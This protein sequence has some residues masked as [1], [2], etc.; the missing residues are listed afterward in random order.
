VNATTLATFLRKVGVTVLSFV[1][2]SLASLVLG[3]VLSVLAGAVISIAVPSTTSNAV[4]VV[5]VL[6]WFSTLAAGLGVGYCVNRVALGR[7]ASWVWVPGL[8]WFALGIRSSMQNY[9]PRWYEGCTAAQNVMNAFFVGDSSKCGGGASTLNSAAFTMP[10]F[11]SIGYSI[12]AW[13]ARRIGLREGLKRWAT[14]RG[15]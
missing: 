11:A 1:A 14:R 8:V 12:G 5:A 4:F 9:D 15:R 7:V 2:H 10:A 3:A 6:W 13:R